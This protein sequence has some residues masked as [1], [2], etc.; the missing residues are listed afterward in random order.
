[1]GTVTGH[2][3]IMHVLLDLA[4]RSNTR[5]RAAQGGRCWAAPL[6][7][8]NSSLPARIPGRIHHRHGNS[9]ALRRGPTGTFDVAMVLLDV[10]APIS[11]RMLTPAARRSTWR[12]SGTSGWRG[13]WWMPARRSTLWVSTGPA[14]CTVRGCRGPREHGRPVAG[15]WGCRQPERPL[16]MGFP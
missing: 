8:H 6:R 1:M 2:G 4:A 7:P 9:A 16:C 11:T 12:S 10:G 3:S 15:A 5:D 14:P 13:C